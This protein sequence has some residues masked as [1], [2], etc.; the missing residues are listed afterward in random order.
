MT[1]KK[2]PDLDEIET[3]A[4]Y[5]WQNNINL[6]LLAL[7]DDQILTTMREVLKK[8]RD[9]GFT[10]EEIKRIPIDKGWIMYDLIK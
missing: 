5:A 9:M 7:L 10:D 4:L 3:N 8:V 1:E 6:Y 2:M